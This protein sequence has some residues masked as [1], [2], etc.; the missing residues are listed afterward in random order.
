MN[1]SQ[2]KSNKWDTWGYGLFW[3]WNLIFLAFMVLGFAPRMLPDLLQE[4]QAG[5]IPARYLVVGLVLSLVPVIAVVL[6]LTYLRQAPRRLFALGYVV[7]GPLMLL[8]GVM[9]FLIRELTAGL[10]LLLAIALLGMAAFLWY[11]LSPLGAR[12][13]RLA[14]WLRLVGLTLMALTSLYAAAWIAFYAVPMGYAALDW[15][16]QVL[17]HLPDFFRNVGL[18]FKDLWGSGLTWIPFMLL[19]MILGLYTAT[20]FALTPIAV[21]VLSLRAWRNAWEP[22]RTRYGWPLPALA[23]AATLAVC[24]ILF[25]VAN[26]QPQRQVFAELASPPQSTAE[27]LKLLEKQDSLRKGLLNAYL[28]PYRYISAL[29][30]VR[31][32]SDLYQNIMKMKPGVCIPRPAV[33][34]GAGPAAALRAGA[35]PGVRRTAR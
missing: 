8:L 18:F 14:G 4:V 3:S 27:A 25:V 28:A 12:R 10:G 29:G 21:P 33:V 34:R 13:S 7:E 31:H 9:F 35:P 5:T 32:V 23:T 24:A 15:L 17:T 19:G 2:I 16:A 1:A 6:G 30:E 22:L 11:V 20:L 26:R